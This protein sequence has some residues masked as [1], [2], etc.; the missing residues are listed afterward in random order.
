MQELE[1]LERPLV[2]L[3]KLRIYLIEVVDRTRK[4]STS[5]GVSYAKPTSPGVNYDSVHQCTSP[6]AL[7][8]ILRPTFVEFSLCF[9]SFLISFYVQS[10]S[11]V[12]LV[13]FLSNSV[14]KKK[15][16]GTT[17]TMAIVAVHSDNSRFYLSSTD[18]LCI[19]SSL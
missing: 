16:C 4:I 13:I 7:P 2:F 19:C 18:F 17:K 9:F 12:F 10:L 14:A 6:A 3:M 5:F 11:C 8:P 1:K 15:S